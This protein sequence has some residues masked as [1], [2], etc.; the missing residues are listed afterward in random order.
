MLLTDEEARQ[1]VS[2]TLDTEAFAILLSA[3]EEAIVDAVGA[4]EYDETPNVEERHFPAGDLLRLS[5]RPSL[6]LSVLE[7]TTELETDDYALR[8]TILRRL[9]DGTNPRSCWWS[10]VTVTYTPVSDVNSRKRAQAEL[11]QLYLA[12]RPGVTSQTIG[13]W[14]EAYGQMSQMLAQQSSILAS[15]R[16]TFEGIR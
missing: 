4:L 12:S 8:G 2:T 7:D 11:L 16:S 10:P 9:A 6:V 5:R 15:I 3:S 13:P 1:F 14:T